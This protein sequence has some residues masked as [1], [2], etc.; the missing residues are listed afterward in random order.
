MSSHT[1]FRSTCILISVLFLGFAGLLQAQTEII[2]T[3]AGNG[4]AGYS[5]DGLKATLAQLSNPTGVAVDSSGNVFVADQAN[6]V[7]RRIDH[8]TQI[9]TTFAGNGIA[10][11]E[12][13]TPFGVCPSYPGDDPG[14]GGPA[15]EAC[16]NNPSGVAVDSAGN[17]FIADTNNDRIRK[18]DTSG[19]I[20]TVAGPGNPGITCPGD[21]LPATS[22]CLV[23]PN[24]VVVDSSGNIFIADTDEERVR[25]VFASNQ[26]I[27]TVAG[28][29]I[30]LGNYNGDGVPATSALLGVPRG[31]ALDSQGNLYIADFGENRVRVVNLSS[32]IINTIAGN[33]NGG[34]VGGYGPNCPNNGGPQP[35]DGGPAT[36]ACLNGPWRVS[37]SQGKIFIGD[38]LNR[39]VRVVQNGII[40]TFSG[41]GDALF[42]GDGGPAFQACLHYPTGVAATSGTNVYIADSQN[43]R[44]RYVYGLFPLSVSLNNNNGGTVT[45]AP[46]G[47]SCP[48]TCSANFPNGSTVTLTGNAN[49]GWIFTGWSG[50]CTGEGPCSIPINAPVSVQANFSPI[51]SVTVM[52][53]GVGTVGSN[54]AGI[55]CPGVCEASFPLGSSVTLSGRPASGSTFAGWGTPCS[56]T[57]LC[58]L[59]MSSPHSVTATFNRS[60]TGPACANGLAIQQINFLNSIPIYKDIPGFA[61]APLIQ[62]PMYVAGQPAQP[63]AYAGNSQMQVAITFSQPTV[64]LSNVTITGTIAGFSSVKL[65]KTLVSI[66]A[67]T[68]TVTV[69]GIMANTVFPPQTKFFNPMSITWTYTTSSGSVVTIGTTANPVYVTLTTPAYGLTTPCKNGPVVTPEIGDS[70]IFL[71]VLALAVGNGGATTTTQ[72][73]FNTWNRFA[74]KDSLGNYVGPANITTWGT[75]T[76]TPLPLYYY[77]N[78]PPVVV[79]FGNCSTFP[80]FTLLT[81]ANG[82][83]QCG[84]FANLMMLALQ[85]N[86]IASYFVTADT[87]DGSE[88]LVKDFAFGPPT[89]PNNAPF[90]WQMVFSA[91]GDPMVCPP[92]NP[93][94]YRTQF[95]DLTSNTTIAGQNSGKLAPSEKVFARHYIVKLERMA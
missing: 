41:A 14:D 77:R 60:C 62:N 1:Q 65:V 94:Y 7:I 35:G 22:A 81:S 43:S 13:V 86:N 18:V 95:G 29:G 46:P 19:T 44:V 84:A 24:D 45:S 90:E 40:Q 48:P 27:V 50:N 25:E 69:P 58:I 78:T 92:Q 34:Y 30:G 74:R 83:G 59:T 16:L 37:V 20:T 10:G 3:F 61:V 36:S 52:G 32:G 70:C 49:V 85:V 64:A 80:I 55:A 73:F 66:P 47:I 23:H 51:L 11:Y 2:T 12:G 57:G 17:I 67:G 9:I 4:T 88:F 76:R 6:N 28:M 87:A 71:S 93:C 63:V 54:P 56:G 53:T 72:A 75:S 38:T 89:L 26:T 21:Y 33:G 5:G 15:I 82:T 42:C 91:N 31:I 79:G 8:A 39:R 68:G